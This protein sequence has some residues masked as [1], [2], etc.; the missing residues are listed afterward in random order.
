MSGI[1][2]LFLSA[3]LVMLAPNTTR[4]E[5]PLSAPRTV[6]AALQAD[7]PPTCFKDPAKGVLQG[8]AIDLMDEVARRAGVK[9][10]YVAGR[11]WQQS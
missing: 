5:A 6:I 3:L 8:F 1:R 9:V 4:A 7:Y 11:T 2:C 10:R